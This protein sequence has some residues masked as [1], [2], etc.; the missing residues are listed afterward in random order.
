LAI[1]Q[2]S[3][4]KNFPQDESKRALSPV[5]NLQIRNGDININFSMNSKAGA[6]ELEKAKKIKFADKLA[7][8]NFKNDCNNVIKIVESV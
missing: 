1:F 6:L 8:R 4:L 2:P 7:E 5:H 3:V